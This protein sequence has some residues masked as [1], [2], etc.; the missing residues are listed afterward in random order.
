[1][2]KVHDDLVS[3]T[4]DLIKQTH[5]HHEKQIQRL[6]KEIRKKDEMNLIIQQ[7]LIKLLRSTWNI[8][9]V[10]NRKFDE[11]IAILSST[12]KHLSE[13]APTAE[14]YDTLSLQLTTGL[15]K[16]FSK[17]NDLKETLPLAPAP[18]STDARGGEGPIKPWKLASEFKTPR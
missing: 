9:D 16:V 4:N 14:A 18:K 1:M 12:F 2:L 17:F 5:V 7:V 8:I 15:Q 3:V 6:E 10:P 11:M 13:Q